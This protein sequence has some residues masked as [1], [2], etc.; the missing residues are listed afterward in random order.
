M[1]VIRTLDL[2]E[3]EKDTIEQ[4]IRDL[5]RRKRERK[6]KKETYNSLKKDLDKRLTRCER[7]LNKTLLDLREELERSR[8]MK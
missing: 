3:A 4:S 8:R 1:E 2:T 7:T 6:I 5:D